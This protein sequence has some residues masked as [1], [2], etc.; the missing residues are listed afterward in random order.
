[1]EAPQVVLTCIPRNACYLILIHAP[2]QFREAI[3][4]KKCSFF[5]IVQKEYLQQDF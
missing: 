1:M 3:I 5:N 4:S 2:F